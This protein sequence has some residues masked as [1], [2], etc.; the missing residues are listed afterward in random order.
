MPRFEQTFC[1]Q[2]GGSFGPGDSGFSHCADHTQTSIKTGYTSLRI[3]TVECPSCRG[4]GYTN[5]AYNCRWCAG[6]GVVSEEDSVAFGA[7][8]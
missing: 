2:C 3:A 1:S 4:R 8:D 5:P 7:D 6:T